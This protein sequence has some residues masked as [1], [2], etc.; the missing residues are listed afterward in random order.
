VAG[1]CQGW[2]AENPAIKTAEMYNPETNYW[3]RVADLPVPISSAR[4]ELLDGLPTIVGGYDNENQ[5]GILYQYHADIDEWKPHPRVRMRIA[6]SS[7]AVFQVP[8]TLFKY[9]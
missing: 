6:R 3:Q 8:K 7:P 4:L 9:C 2:C 1:G 5:N